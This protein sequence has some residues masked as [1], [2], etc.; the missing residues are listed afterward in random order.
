M[1]AEF[2]RSKV[3]LIHR[4][5]HTGE[6][7]SIKRLKKQAKKKIKIKLINWERHVS[8]DPLLTY[9]HAKHYLSLPPVCERIL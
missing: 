1:L 8:L 4:Y 7:N 5:M 6:A 2:N 3:T 9:H